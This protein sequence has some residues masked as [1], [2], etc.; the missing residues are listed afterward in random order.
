M[1]KDKRKD[2]SK[3]SKKN[4]QLYEIA[5]YSFQF[6]TLSCLI[7]YIVKPDNAISLIGLCISGV[8]YSFSLIKK[9]GEFIIK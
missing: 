3:E 9:S 6:A 2:K 4:N 1:R 8:V 7:G 5:V